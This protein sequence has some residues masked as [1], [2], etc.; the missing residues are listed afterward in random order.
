[1]NRVLVTGANGFVGNHLIHELTTN[2]YEVVGVGGPVATSGMPTGMADY[3][4]RVLA[5]QD[6]N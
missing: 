4:A 2:G 5:E 1:M 3:I 6:D